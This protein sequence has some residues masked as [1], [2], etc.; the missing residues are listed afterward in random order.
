MAKQKLTPVRTPFSRAGL[1]LKTLLI[2]FTQ[3][4]LR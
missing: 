1:Q 2:F 4:T 3:R